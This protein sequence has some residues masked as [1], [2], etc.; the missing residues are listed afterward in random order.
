[1]IIKEFRNKLNPEVKFYFA[2]DGAAFC[3]HARLDLRN[4]LDNL[5]FLC[6]SP[7]KNLGGSEST[8]VL[9]GKLKSYPKNKA[10]SFPG[11]GT[12]LAVTGLNYE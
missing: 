3:S 8:G 6:L 12:V 10:P 7:H 11:G 2:V 4:E 9:I 1:M 5:D